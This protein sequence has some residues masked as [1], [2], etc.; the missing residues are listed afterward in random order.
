M[1]ENESRKGNSEEECKQ[2]GSERGGKKLCWFEDE[3]DLAAI[4]TCIPEERWPVI[5]QVFP[6]DFSHVTK[7]ALSEA[8]RYRSTERQIFADLPAIDVSTSDLSLVPF[9]LD[10][11][12]KFLDT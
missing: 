4:Y 7:D 10:G 9:I 3:D 12:T 1:R 6:R 11:H 2:H 5:Y 8:T